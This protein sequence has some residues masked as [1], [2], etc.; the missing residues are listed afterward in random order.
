MIRSTKQR[1]AIQDVFASMNR[2]L[3]VE[4]VLQAASASSGGIGI[5]TV[6]R[7]IKALVDDGILTVVELPGEGPRYELSGKGHHHHFHCRQ[8]GRV[9]DVT[10]C[11]EGL[12]QMMPKGFQITGHEIV[13]YG[14][15]PACRPA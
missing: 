11:L 7:N 10:T 1:R 5:A 8:C 12:K 13:L 15:C 2:P 6:Y 3:A 9:F 14:N 4:E